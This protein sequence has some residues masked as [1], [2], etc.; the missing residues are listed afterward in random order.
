MKP[1]KYSLEELRDFIRDDQYRGFALEG[2]IL[3]VYISKDVINK[4]NVN[5]LKSFK[6]LW[7]ESEDEFFLDFVFLEEIGGSYEAL[8]LHENEDEL[9]IRAFDSIRLEGHYSGLGFSGFGFHF[10]DDLKEFKIYFVRKSHISYTKI[11]YLKTLLQKFPEAESYLHAR[12]RIQDIEKIDLMQDELY[13]LKSINKDLYKNPIK[14]LLAGF[15]IILI[16]YYSASVKLF[17]LVTIVI[18]ISYN[19]TMASRWIMRYLV[20]KDIKKLNKQI[21][22]KKETLFG[23][24]AYF[25]CPLENNRFI[26][27]LTPIIQGIFKKNMR[28]KKDANEDHIFIFDAQN[29]KRLNEKKYYT[30]PVIK[31][32][33]SKYPYTYI[34]LMTHYDTDIQGTQVHHWEFKNQEIRKAIFSRKS[35]KN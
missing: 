28:S 23:Q 18:V 17:N 8:V 30:N 31:V 29:F 14:V 25:K 20:N 32:V 13:E 15:F 33:F 12:Q 1:K 2:W 4:D 3:R 26:K 24:I 11:H 7:T 9:K 10:F 19:T 22:K 34:S 21:L 27:V 6:K 35:Q 16:L 5:D